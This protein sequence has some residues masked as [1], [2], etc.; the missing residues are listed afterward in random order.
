[1]NHVIN[2]CTVVYMQTLKVFIGLPRFAQ[3]GYSV[4]VL[5]FI[6]LCFHRRPGSHPSFPHH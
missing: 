6:F 2:K 4:C 1:M 5:V 3:P